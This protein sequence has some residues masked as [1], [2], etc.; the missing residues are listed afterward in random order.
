MMMM[1]LLDSHLPL[2]SHIGK[3]GC[4]GTARALLLL[5]LLLL[6]LLLVIWMSLLRMTRWSSLLRI[7][8][9]PHRTV[10]AMIS[11]ASSL[12]RKVIGY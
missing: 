8:R 6:L 3:N 2:I 9:W 4:R 7:H 10:P 12:R 5:E 1:M 11:S